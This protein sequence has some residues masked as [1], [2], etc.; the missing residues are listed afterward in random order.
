V[1]VLLDAVVGTLLVAFVG[2]GVGHR[3]PVARLFANLPEPRVV[4]VLV[5]VFIRMVVVLS[6]FAGLKFFVD[7]LD[8]DIQD[9]VHLME[10]VDLLSKLLL[11]VL[12]AAR[13]LL[14]VLITLALHL[15]EMVLQVLVPVEAHFRFSSL[16]ELVDSDSLLD[17][18]L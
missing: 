1:L 7:G 9:L 2:C 3:S 4:V 11:D 8:F 14:V 13:Q 12:V 5:A 10:L 16:L 17:H 6:S 15:V 18:S